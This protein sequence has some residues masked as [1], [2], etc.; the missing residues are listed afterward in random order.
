MLL[1]LCTPIDIGIN[2]LFIDLKFIQ[3]NIQKLEH[4]RSAPDA[5]T[6]FLA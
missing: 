6:N 1:N 5:G 3:K 4:P 2:G